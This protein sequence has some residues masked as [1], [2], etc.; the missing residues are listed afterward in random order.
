MANVVGRKSK[1]RSRRKGRS[2]SKSRGRTSR[3]I[4]AD[5]QVAY[6]GKL[7]TSQGF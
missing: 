4:D 3:G 5:G 1:S 6:K 7:L 2:R